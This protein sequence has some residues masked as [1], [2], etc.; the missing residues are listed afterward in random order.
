[1]RVAV[2]S[3]KP[4]DRRSLEAADPRGRHDWELWD[5]RLTPETARLAAG[6]EAVC[7]F[8]ND[9]LGAEVVDA[10]ADAG[11]RLIALRSAGYNHL[12]RAAA[13]ARGLTVGRVPAYSPHAVAEHTVALVLTLNRKTH[14]AFN[15]V[16]DGNF[17]LEGLL[18][19][20]LFGKTVGIVGTGLIG[21]TLARIM[22]GF[23]CRVIA[24]DPR[25]NPECLALGVVYVG[26][27]PLLAES[28]IVTLQCP[29]TAATHHLIDD[30]AI[31]GLKR[32]AM[33]INTSRGGLID[34]RAAIRGLRSG[35][36]GGLGLDVYEEEAGLFFE[37][38]SGSILSDD[39]FTRL[40]T[41]PNV[42]ITGHQAF[43]TEEALRAIAE[44]TVANITSFEQDGTVPHP[45]PA[46]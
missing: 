32:G 11:A 33:L 37:D 2:F 45:L 15:R 24:H 31:A 35:A 1:M 23:G 5:T 44:A 6:A 7:A 16:R 9:D 10:L 28:D 40:L 25:P 46:S 39:V 19:F 14:R 38:L 17:A 27:A 41:F 12:D 20:D 43:F 26:I 34:T 42:L 8:V 30:A 4:Y 21:A 29:L 18:G 36:I 13:A 22:I 3:A